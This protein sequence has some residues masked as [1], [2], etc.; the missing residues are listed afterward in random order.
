MEMSATF[1]RDI[2]VLPDLFDLVGTFFSTESIDPRLRFPIDFVLEEIF[3]NF[4]KYNPEGKSDIG[5]R[6]AREDD[7]L[8]IALSDFD[9]APFDIHKDVPIVDTAKPLQERVP[10]RLGV[11]LVKQLMDR[12]EYAHEDR[13]STITMY[14]DL[15]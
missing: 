1:R 7:Y 6:L 2:G 3:T 9:S 10:G 11:H 12:V 14:K 4:V 13:V 15:R 8:K 5:V